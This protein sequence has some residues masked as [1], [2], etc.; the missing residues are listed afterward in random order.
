[1]ARSMSNGR[2]VG[3]PAQGH[4]SI[5]KTGGRS[6]YKPDAAPVVKSRGSVSHP[7]DTGNWRLKRLVSDET[8]HVVQG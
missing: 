4:N 7:N 1:M 5:A 8:P 2:N 3:R 6:A